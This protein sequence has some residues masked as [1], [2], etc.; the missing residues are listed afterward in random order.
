M[1]L[2]LICLFA[3]CS[4]YL[5]RIWIIWSYFRNEPDTEVRRIAHFILSL[6]LG[7]IIINVP[8]ETISTNFEIQNLIN[9]FVSL[10][11]CSFYRDWTSLVPKV[12]FW[13]CFVFLR[14][15]DIFVGF[16]GQKL[17]L[18]EGHYICK[19]DF[20][21]ITTQL[22]TTEFLINEI[23]SS[24]FQLLP[25]MGQSFPTRGW[26]KPWRRGDFEAVEGG[27]KGLFFASK[28]Q[29]GRWVWRRRKQKWIGF[30]VR[31]LKLIRLTQMICPNSKGV[32]SVRKQL[33]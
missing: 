2:F 20:R 27:K 30:Y 22:L 23:V 3:L 33:T 4:S 7:L 8:L 10:N 26:N 5:P 17:D 12:K 11:S 25:R 32:L 1:S 31:I 13:V 24:H 19:I 18:R 21:K 28:G 15:T 14:F 6:Y 29:R 16:C 9:E